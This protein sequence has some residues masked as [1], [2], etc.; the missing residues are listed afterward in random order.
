MLS[1]S[2]S[3]VKWFRSPLVLIVGCSLYRGTDSTLAHVARAVGASADVTVAASDL[4]VQVLNSTTT[5]VAFVSKLAWDVTSSSLG[6]VE[7]TWQGIDL[8]NV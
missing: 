7:A 1:G 8:L 4:A 2:W 3:F 5:G 6:L